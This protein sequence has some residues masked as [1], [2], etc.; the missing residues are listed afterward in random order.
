MC[1]QYRSCNHGSLHC[2]TH[3]LLPVLAEDKE[4]GSVLALLRAGLLSADGEGFDGK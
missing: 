1:V 3:S 2:Y 4:L